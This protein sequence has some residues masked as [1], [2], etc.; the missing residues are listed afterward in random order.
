[1]PYGM[2]LKLKNNY[3]HKPGQ[4]III[5][6]AGPFA[7]ILMI[8]CVLL[9]K[10]YCRFKTD[11]MTFFILANTIIVVTNLLPV[12]PLDGG[13][14]MRSFLTMRW[15]FIKA[16]NFTLKVTGICAAVVF[17]CGAWILYITHFNISLFIISLFLVWNMACERK[18]TRLIV[19][20]ELIY[21]KDK[22][23]KEGIMRTRSIAALD[24]MPARKLL[25]Y[26]SY[27]FFYLI[28]VINSEMNV[29]GILTEA[30][31]IEGMIKSGSH[32]K[33]GDIYRNIYC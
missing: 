32:V 17:L 7:N 30:Q 19:A 33:V 13:K 25:S 1:M 20:K 18:N 12:L 29:V 3:I 21:C 23:L 31:I 16:S 28:T 6:A 2:T 5:A 26:F 14:I 10:S 22:L 9:L 4:E 24:D 15:G 11:D 8:F 27:N